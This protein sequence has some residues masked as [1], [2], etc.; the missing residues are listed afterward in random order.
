RI[1]CDIVRAYLE[2]GPSRV[3]RVAILVAG[4]RAYKRVLFHQGMPRNDDLFVGL[5]AAILRTSRD[6]MRDVKQR[7]LESASLRAAVARSIRPIPEALELFKRLAT[8]DTRRHVVATNPIMP[9]RFNALRLAEA[10]Y[11]IERFDY[12]CGSEDFSGQKHLPSFY[13]DL[14]ARLHAD[15]TEAM[16]IGNDPKKDLA[17]G[18]TGIRTFL[19][20]TPFTVLRR[21]WP[22]RPDWEGDYGTL[23][24]RLS[25]GGL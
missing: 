23:E 2:H 9:A 6:E 21:D 25:E 20:R 14:L 13:P 24:K 4:A 17:V 12:I 18:A 11:P 10:G 22:G 1:M 5:M 7:F 16:M 15:P 19:L 3:S 8:T